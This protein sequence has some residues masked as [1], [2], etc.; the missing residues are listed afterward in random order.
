MARLSIEM[1]LGYLNKVKPITRS[2]VYY[3]HQA[4]FNR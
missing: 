4:D 1:A 3:K 2:C